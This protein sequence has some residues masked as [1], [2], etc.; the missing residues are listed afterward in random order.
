MHRG[1]LPEGFQMPAAEYIGI[2][3]GGERQK[4]E[5]GGEQGLVDFRVHQRCSMNGFA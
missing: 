2:A 5:G 4:Y 1:A 3:M